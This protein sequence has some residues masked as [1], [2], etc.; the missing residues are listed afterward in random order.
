MNGETAWLWPCGTGWHIQ[1]GHLELNLH[2]Y[3]LDGE[4]W[5]SVDWYS[6]SPVGKVTFEG[7]VVEIG[8]GHRNVETIT[9]IVDDLFQK[10]R[11]RETGEM[12][13]DKLEI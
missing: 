4:P 11:Q 2:N 7:G 1:Q 8:T 12:V 9:T 3:Q 5:H 10:L 13:A 6:S